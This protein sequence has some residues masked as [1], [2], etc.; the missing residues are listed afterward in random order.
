MRNYELTYIL[1][2][3]LSEKDIPKISEKIKGLFA[4]KIVKEDYWGK[5]RFA[6]P[7]KKFGKKYEDGFYLTLH[8][9]TE[10]EKIEELER[11]LKLEEEILRHLIVSKKE[12]K[13]IEKPKEIKKP[14]KVKVKPK[15]ERPKPK[16]KEEKKRIKALEEKL[17]EI[18]KE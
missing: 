7:I 13:V 17:E 12:K 11:K 5:K 18:L 15:V 9:Q 1:S 3:E 10:P 16:I 2:S 4:G 8:F 14:K 6:Y